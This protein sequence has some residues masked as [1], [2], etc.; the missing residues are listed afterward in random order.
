MY[1]ACLALAW[2]LTA[3]LCRATAR[4]VFSLHHDLLLDCEQH[5][6]RRGT[7]E[8]RLLP[9]TKLARRIGNLRTGRLGYRCSYRGGICANWEAS[10]CPLLSKFRTTL[11]PRRCTRRT[12]IQTAQIQPAETQPNGKMSE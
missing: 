8:T 9:R 11:R 10:I 3:W 12:Q 7:T 4:G 5:V 1:L 2:L 6:L